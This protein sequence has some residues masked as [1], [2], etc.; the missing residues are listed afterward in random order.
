M[1]MTNIG[2][3]NILQNGLIHFAV[4]LI[5]L[6]PIPAIG[7]TTKNMLH[8]FTYNIILTDPSASV[9]VITNPLPKYHMVVIN[10]H[11]GKEKWWIVNTKSSPQREKIMSWYYDEKT[12]ILT[13]QTSQKKILGTI[14]IDFVINLPENYDLNSLGCKVFL[15]AKLDKELKQVKTQLK[16]ETLTK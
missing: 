5:S 13:L 15:S 16:L 9:F 3:K 12:G 10:I 4:L 11:A 1:C 8:Y 14:E 2:K 7:Q 6:P